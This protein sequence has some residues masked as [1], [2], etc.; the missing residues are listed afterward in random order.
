MIKK[1]TTKKVNIYGLKDSA[2]N[3][4]P[5]ERNQ[6][7]GNEGQSD[8]EFLAAFKATLLVQARSLG[9]FSRKSEVIAEIGRISMSNLSNF[10]SSGWLAVEYK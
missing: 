7:N 1:I 3:D 9:E 10:I 6:E 2:F 8:E 4:F 5:Y